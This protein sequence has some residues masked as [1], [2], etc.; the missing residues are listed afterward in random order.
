MSDPN[1]RLTTAE[2]ADRVAARWREGN[3]PTDEEIDNTTYRCEQCGGGVFRVER[4]YDVVHSCTLTLDCDCSD[5]NDRAAVITCERAVQYEA[6]GELDD[7]HRVTWES[8]EE[9]DSTEEEVDRD[10]FCRDCVNSSIDTDW[11]RED[12]EDEE[13]DDELYILCGRCGH[14]IEFGWSHPDRGGRIWP[15]E[16]A[17]FNPYKS[18]PETRY[19]EDWAERGWL[20]PDRGQ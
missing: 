8:T 16:A 20:R 12:K 13:G 11:E 15:C 1:K 5:D 9:V 2:A 3:R 4:Y 10:V 17:D 6:H 18:W 19:L 7:D 14:E